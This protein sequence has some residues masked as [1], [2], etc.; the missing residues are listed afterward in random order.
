MAEN[1]L[2][3]LQMEAQL[4]EADARLDVLQA[5]A[6]AHNAQ[7]EMDEISGVR[8]RRDQA[9][10]K[11]DELKQ[12]AK[13]NLEKAR[14]DASTAFRELQVEIERV[15]D[16]YS[17]WDEARERRFEARLDEIQAKLKLW[18]AKGDQKRAEHGMKRHDALA[19]LET[20]FEA[21]R[22]RHAEW[23]AHRHDQKAEAALDDASQH[24]DKA[25]AAAASKY[26]S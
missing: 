16:R 7:Q 12:G 1:D 22:A 23:R 2:S 14:H 24:L 18:K 15:K 4:H 9:R 5:Q 3:D 8:R 25:Y 17:V 20:R 21:A 19:D 10:Q 6:K 26:E 11:L 13:G